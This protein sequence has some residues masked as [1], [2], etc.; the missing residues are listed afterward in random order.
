MISEEKMISYRNNITK[1]ISVLK[2][3]QNSLKPTSVG[4]IS[5]ENVLDYIDFLEN[6]L[7]GVKIIR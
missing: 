7:R 4:Y 6:K 3:I 1:S 5:I 2:D